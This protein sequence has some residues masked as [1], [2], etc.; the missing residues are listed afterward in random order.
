MNTTIEIISI[1]A[2]ALAVTGVILNNRKSIY[3]FIF[4]L[5]SNA[6]SAG[7]HIHAGLYGL[8]I[9]DLIFMVLA[10]EGIILWK[11]SKK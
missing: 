5:C 2:T 4:W 3:C 11:R 8:T 1:V 7:I 9:R 6:L 10:V